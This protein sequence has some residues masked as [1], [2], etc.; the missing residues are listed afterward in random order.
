MAATAAWVLAALVVGMV[1][2]AEP[3]AWAVVVGA[4]VAATDQ[5]S[6]LEQILVEVVVALVRG[7]PV[8]VWAALAGVKG[9]Q[10]LAAEDMVAA[11]L[12]VE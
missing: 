6:A 1:F 3:Q 11:G 4:A 12:A 5:W 8:V 7:S 9:A 10:V 2:G